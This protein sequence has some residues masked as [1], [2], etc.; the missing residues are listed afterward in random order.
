M[1]TNHSRTSTRIKRA[2]V[3][4]AV[5]V[6]SVAVGMG[7]GI[8]PAHA[9]AS[10]VFISDS[11]PTNG[12]SV[13]VAGFATAGNQ[14]SVAECNI[15]ADATTATACNQTATN[16]YTVVTANGMGIWSATIVV[17]N[18]FV[19]ASFSP[20]PPVPGSTVC[21]AVSGSNGTCAIQAQEYSAGFVPVGLPA[22]SNL[23]F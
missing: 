7:A 18:G 23:T 19:N 10:I 16:R 13:M 2:V 4:T 22:S 20:A 9:A 5:V 8:T 21:A 6:A 14:V 15:T 3:A 11:T 17:D 1:V 12:Q